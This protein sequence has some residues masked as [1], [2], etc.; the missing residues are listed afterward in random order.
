MK[1]PSQDKDS[2]TNS[3][4]EMPEILREILE[5][6]AEIRRTILIE[7]PQCLPTLAPAMIHAEARIND[8]FYPVG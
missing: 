7:A 6:L 4:N 3:N 5:D 1:T 2:D 8:V